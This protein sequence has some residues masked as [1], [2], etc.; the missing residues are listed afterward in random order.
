MSKY[1]TQLRHACAWV[2]R[3]TVENWFKEYDIADYLLPKQIEVVEKAGLF[4][5][6]RLARE[7]VDTYFMREIGLETIELFHH[8]V[9]INMR[10]I[11][12]RALP[13]IYTLS[14]DY[15]PLVNVDYKEEFSRNISRE[16]TNEGN[17]TSN[18][19]QNASALTINSDTPQNN[20]NKEDIL[21]GTYASSTSAGESD[22]T[23]VDTVQSN[24][25]GTSKDNETYTK[26][27]KGNSGVLSTNQK[28]IEQYRQ[29]IRSVYD[30]IIKELNV[31]FM[32][33]Y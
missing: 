21:N 26:H 3:D 29:N 15:D 11:M 19:N 20:I 13:L 12:E 17:S 24:T 8:Y 1:T 31:L 6:D 14:I 16:N 25:T 4:N 9:I 2:G 10:R 18:S 7:I 27:M 22:S 28:L 23:S 33:I 30:E 32:S 5:K